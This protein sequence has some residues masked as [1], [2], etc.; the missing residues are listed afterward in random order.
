MIFESIVRSVGFK[1]Y[2]QSACTFIM[3]ID[4]VW[5][6]E[7]TFLMILF[8]AR[9]YLVI[10]ILTKSRSMSKKFGTILFTLFVYLNIWL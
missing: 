8:S 9:L 2:R 4:W 7:F 5:K 6:I 1:H 10:I 3:Y